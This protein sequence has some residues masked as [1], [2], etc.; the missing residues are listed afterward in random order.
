MQPG[1]SAN[2]EAAHFVRMLE[3]PTHLDRAEGD[4]HPGG[5]PHIQTDP[6][7]IAKVGEALAQRLA[8]I[9]VPNAAYYQTREKDF[10]QR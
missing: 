5:N 6:R 4:V 1:K 3:I 8:E 2:F 7:N 10:A 9:D